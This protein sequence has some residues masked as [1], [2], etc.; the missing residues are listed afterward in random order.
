MRANRY[1]RVSD[2]R[3]RVRE[4]S[5][6]LL[7]EVCY[8]ED[9]DDEQR[10]REESVERSSE[11]ERKDEQHAEWREG[12]RVKSIPWRRRALV[13]EQGHGERNDEHRPGN[14]A[15]ADTTAA[16][17]RDKVPTCVAKL[18]CERCGNV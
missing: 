9:N 7:S 3:E 8:L 12:E 13:H 14:I 10:C 11:N 6:I 1:Y 15:A 18:A 4:L 5:V 2:E 16:G 17:K